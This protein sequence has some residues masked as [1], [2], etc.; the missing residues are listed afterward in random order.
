MPGTDYQ[1]LS[2]PYKSHAWNR[3]SDT[4]QPMQVSCLEQTIIHFTTP[5]N[6]MP[7]IDYQTLNNQ[8]LC[9]ARNRLS[10]TKHPIF[11]SCLEQ[12]IRH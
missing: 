7:R 2:P 3:L 11:I 10:D 6:L 9:H 12:T 5:T 8:Y 4:K 1:T